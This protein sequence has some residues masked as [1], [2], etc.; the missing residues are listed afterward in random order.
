MYVGKVKRK[1]NAFVRN[2]H[3][4]CPFSCKSMLPFTEWEELRRLD[5]VANSQVRR[6]LLSDK[7]GKGGAE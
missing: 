2:L 5:K 6:P 1:G 7:Y 3:F 4:R